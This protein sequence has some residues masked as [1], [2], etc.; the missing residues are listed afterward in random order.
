MNA[1]TPNSDL[2]T[3]KSEQKGAILAATPNRDQAIL[4]MLKNA[5]NT[6][7]FDAIIIPLKV[8]AGDSY[9]Y[10]IIND[11]TVLDDASPLPPIM[12]TQG[13]RAVSSISNCGSQES[14][15]KIAAIMRPCE[16]LATIELAKLKQVDLENI[17]LISMD[18][19]GVLPMAEFIKDPI[20]GEDTFDS[21]TEKWDLEPM[22]PVC[23]ICDKFGM[24]ASDIHIGTLGIGNNSILL[25]PNSDKGK[26]ILDTLNLEIKEPIETWSKTI[27]ELTTM[28]RQKKVE[29][30]KN[31]ES[32][33]LG[34]DNLL[35][36]FSTCI[37]CHNCM[38][39]CPIC[40]CRQ[41]YFDSEVTKH[42]PDDY[43]L[44]AQR[45]GSLRFLPD[46]LLFHIGRM[47]H[48]SISC[49][50]CGS[51]EDAC[52]MDIPVAQIFDKIAHSTQDLFDYVP[53]KDL[54]EPRPLTTFDK[55]ELQDV[56]D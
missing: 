38:R 20:K 14:D 31:L 23:Q 24:L 3:I 6:K 13:A 33:I 47:M 18:C 21:S 25:I 5:M 45:S 34:L 36:A 46:N 35:D 41:C 50:S 12:T 32:N 44:R 56:E 40:S 30:H 15:L 53:G 7:C 17:I 16:I 54:Q 49:V 11:P 8:P 48:M 4:D 22:R 2:G 52:P 26:K 55:N 10:L 43:L 27:D 29:H 42:Q 37:N 51:C 19:P 1:D 9:T 39:V 28:R